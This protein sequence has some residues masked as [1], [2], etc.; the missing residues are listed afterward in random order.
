MLLPINLV[1]CVTQATKLKG[2]CTK[3][4]A[5]AFSAYQFEKQEL[6]LFSRGKRYAQTLVWVE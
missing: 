3:Q 1:A 2:L 5:K 4:K 6:A